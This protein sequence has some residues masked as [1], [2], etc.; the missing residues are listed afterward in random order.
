LNES[1]KIQ[2]QRLENFF[3]QIKKR[4]EREKNKTKYFYFEVFSKLASAILEENTNYPV[5]IEHIR[6]LLKNYISGLST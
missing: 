5:S 2:F 1:V 6:I 4:K 3:G